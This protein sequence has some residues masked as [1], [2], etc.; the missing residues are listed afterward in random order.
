M[1]PRDDEDMS[2]V[3][4]SQVE[5]CHGQV[6]VRNNGRR[7]PAGDIVAEYTSANRVTIHEMNRVPT[8]RPS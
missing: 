2:W 8:Q 6:I 7:Q 1:L 4:L 3:E 5:K